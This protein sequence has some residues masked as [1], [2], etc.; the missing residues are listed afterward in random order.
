MQCPKCRHENE[1]G[2]TFC[3]ECAAPLGR[4][5]VKCGRRLSPQSSVPSAQIKTLTADVERR[6]H[7]AARVF[8]LPIDTDAEAREKLCVDV[9]TNGLRTPILIDRPVTEAGWLIIDGRNRE[10][11]C[12]ICGIEQKY[13]VVNVSDTAAVVRVISANLLCRHER[14]DRYNPR[15]PD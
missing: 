5:C 1:D 9:A 8:T 13:E 14:I 11:A 12:L 15:P 10:L 2:A 7:P 6:S 3:E 4:A